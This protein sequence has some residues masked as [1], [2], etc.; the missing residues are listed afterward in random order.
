MSG[1]PLPSRDPSHPQLDE[2][3]R[4]SSRPGANPELNSI[5]PDPSPGLSS[6]PTRRSFRILD[7]EPV[8]RSRTNKDPELTPRDLAILQEL[9]EHRYLDREQ[10]Q[11][12]FFPGPRSCQYRLRWLH[13]QGLVAAWRAATRPGRTCR[14]SIYLL[15]QRGA[16]L[17][18]E[19]RGDDPRPYLRRSE[20]ALE[21]N[22]HLVHQLEANWFFVVLA[23]ATRDDPD[24]GLYHWV[25]EHAIAAAYAEGQEQGPIPD[26]WGRLLTQD[27]E[28]LLHLEW[29][30]GTEQPRRLRLKLL[31][32]LRYFVDRPHASANQILLVTPT[33]A[34][35]RQ[36]QSLLHDPVDGGRECCRFWTTTTELLRAA[37]PLAPI[38]WADGERLSLPAMAGLPRSQRSIADCI[39]KPEWWL[40]RP[41]A[42]AGT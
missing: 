18:A 24:L 5:W 32:Y 17:L 27:S 34:R 11:S 9:D 3:S 38:W 28:P 4:N 16:A 36:L 21:R 1:L 23:A 14:A 41:G 35:E 10:I 22:F 2:P 40:R 8:S 19:W 12:L 39:G 42:G 20:H 37:G 7:L 6:L 31:S 29:D 33:P 26:G 15:S 25:G 13:E 30:R